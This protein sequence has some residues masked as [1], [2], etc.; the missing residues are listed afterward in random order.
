MAASE[1]LQPTWEMVGNAMST[2]A[3]AVEA[4]WYTQ[5]LTIYIR[6][7]SFPAMI[8]VKIIC[9]VKFYSEILGL[10]LEHAIVIFSLFF[11]SII[12]IRLFSLEIVGV[13]CVYYK[14]ISNSNNAKFN[15]LLQ[16]N[17]IN[18]GMK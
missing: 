6:D 15:R 4:Y 14:D 13:R 1:R 9:W 3:P 17:L 12:K 11:W 16:I 10:M 2:T 8:S 7:S 5:V 18:R